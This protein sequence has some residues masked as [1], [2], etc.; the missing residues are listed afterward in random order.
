MAGWIA[1]RFLND[2]AVALVH[3]AHIDDGS[4]NPVVL[5]RAAYWRGRSNQPVQFRNEKPGQLGRGQDVRMF[6]ALALVGLIQRCPAL[7]SP[8]GGQEADSAH[9]HRVV[10]PT[11]YVCPDART[12]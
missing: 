12:G 10:F 1:L 9:S 6:N 8:T 7:S 5:A 4:A 11:P 2:P 3:F